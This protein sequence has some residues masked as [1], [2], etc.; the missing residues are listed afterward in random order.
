VRPRRYTDRTI[1]AHNDSSPP[2]SRS[3][4]DAAN[5][6][7]TFADESTGTDGL[8]QVEEVHCDPEPEYRES[9]QNF[10]E[11]LEDIWERDGEEGFIEFAFDPI[12]QQRTNVMLNTLTASIAGMHKEEVLARLA[13]HD[14]LISFLPLDYLCALLHQSLRAAVPSGPASARTHTDVIHLRMACRGSQ[15][16]GSNLIRMETVKLFDAEGQVTQVCPKSQSVSD[17]VFRNKIFLWEHFTQRFL[18]RI[19][20]AIF[21]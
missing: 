12:T 10:L 3:I 11:C 4:A 14:A 8:L 5:K 21:T 20:H 16:R 18:N 1:S 15:R 7:A 2:R 9:P 19:S 6:L 17:I 13:A